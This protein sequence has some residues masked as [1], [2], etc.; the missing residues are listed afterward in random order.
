M[1][2]KKLKLHL[3]IFII[4]FFIIN[5]LSVKS[6]Q[7]DSSL[8]FNPLVD[9]IAERLPPLE[10]LIDSAVA[11]APNVKFDEL[12]MSVNKYDIKT[13][14]NE[15]TKYLGV[16]TLTEWGTWYYDDKDELTRINRFYLTTSKRT[17]YNIGVYIKFPLY[18]IINRRNMININKKRL[19]ETMIDRE[20]RIREIRQLV[21]SEYNRLLEYQ[22][23]IKV[24][25]K[26]QQY[27]LVQMR[28]AEN[29][30]LNNQIP[31]SELARLKEIQKTGK[32]EFVKYKSEFYNAYMILQ[33]MVGIKFNLINELK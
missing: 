17:V 8:Y 9:N 16:Q 23:L 32:V 27:T 11:N 6:Q 3:S 18:N 33:E 24:S 7:V 31:A 13:A 15:W 26:F 2:L 22:E 28:M 14:R 25:N 5:S 29:D 21:I 19:E 20:K 30:F 12:E 4:I 10:I 1:S